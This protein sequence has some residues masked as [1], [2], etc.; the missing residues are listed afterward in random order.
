MFCVSGDFAVVGG[1]RLVA[2]GRPPGKRLRRVDDQRSVARVDARA[3]IG[4]LD[5]LAQD[6]RHFLGMDRQLERGEAVVGE[7]GWL[8]PWSLGNG[9]GIDDDALAHDLG[10]GG[11]GVGDDLALRLEGVE[12]GVDQPGVEPAEIEDAADEDDEPHQVRDQDAAQEAGREEA[13]DAAGG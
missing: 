13:H 1:G 10:V 5:E 9:V 2:H 6:R 12:L 4:R 11:D 3:R 7:A 8:S